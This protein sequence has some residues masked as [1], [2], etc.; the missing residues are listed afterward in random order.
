MFD[1]DNIK[2]G[3][4]AINNSFQRWFLAAVDNS[5]RQMPQNIDH[6]ATDS[7]FQNGCKLGAD[8]WQ[9]RG[10]REELKQFLWSLWM[11][12]DFPYDFPCQSRVSSLSGGISLAHST[13]CFKRYA[14][15]I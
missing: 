12:N 11:H 15:H 2:G 13:A 8:A 10:C 6:I 7:F 4:S 14:I 9:S 1:D 3:Y 5:N